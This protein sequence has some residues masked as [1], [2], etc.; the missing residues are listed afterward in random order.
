MAL[1]R[2]ARFWERVRSGGPILSDG[3]MGSELIG[4]GIAAEAVTLANL[5]H[6]CTVRSIH[7]AYIAAGCELITANTFGIHASSTWAAECLAGLEIAVLAAMATTRDIGVWLSLP[8]AVVVKERAALRMLCATARPPRPMLLIE[9]CISLDT[10]LAAARAAVTI[11][12]D[13]LAVTAHFRSDGTLPDGTGAEE[14]A[15]ALEREGA[16]VLGA[17]CGDSLQSFVEITARMRSATTA[18]LLIQPSAGLPQQDG[19]GQWRY[20]VEPAQFAKVAGQLRDAGASIVGG[21]C[22]AGSRHIAAMSRQM[23]GSR[24]PD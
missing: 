4:Q 17:N 15:M 21:C 12:P 2:A 14:F 13:V 6:G 3:A 1:L 10:A 24:A 7:D 20:P 19:T 23:G 11:A 5:D 8:A 16:Q 22:G 18:P 9:T